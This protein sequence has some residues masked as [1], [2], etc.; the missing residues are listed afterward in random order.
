MNHE[1]RFFFSAF[2]F[3][4]KFEVSIFRLVV[5]KSRIRNVLQFIA[6]QNLSI[7]FCLHVYQHLYFTQQ[8]IA[9]TAAN[10]V[11]V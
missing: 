11:Y 3:F 1:R 8:N 2:V 5:K 9:F 10:L 6:H 7:N 4:L